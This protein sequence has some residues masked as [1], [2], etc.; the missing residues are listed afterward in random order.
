MNPKRIP[1]WTAVC[2]A[3]VLA[4][5][6][7][8]ALP[9]NVP[10]GRT[11]VVG[12]TNDSF[13]YT[14]IGPDGTLK[15]FNVD[16]LA[17]VMRSEHMNY[18]IIAA[19]AQ[20]ILTRFKAGEFDFM[21]E[22]VEQSDFNVFAEFSVPTI[23]T[24]MGI[25]V[26]T[27]SGISGPEDLAGRTVAFVNKGSLGVRYLTDHHIG[28]I[29]DFE[30]N[31]LT[32]LRAVADGRADATIIGRFTAQALM[33][34]NHVPGLRL[35]DISMSGYD[36]RRCLAVH[37]GDTALLAQLND[38]L[39]NIQ[40]NG[41]Y[42][43]IYSQ[44]KGKYDTKRFT[45][46]EVY[47]WGVAA[48]VTAFLAALW[49]LL[50]QRRLHRALSAQ[51]REISSQRALLQ[52][53]YD[54][55]PIG[56]TV[57][58]ATPSGPQVVLKNREA[59]AMTAEASRLLI[60]D[61]MR[62]WQAGRGEFQFDYDDRA[63]SRTYL[64]TV[65]PLT[66]SGGETGRLCVLFDDIT[67]RRRAEAEV[68]QSRKLRAVGELVGGIAHEFNN[69]LTPI[70]LKTGELQMTNPSAEEL[71]Q[72]LEV[73]AGAAMRG[74][75]LTRRLLT[76][77]RKTDSRPANIDVARIVE[78]CFKLLCNTVDRRIVWENAVP[79]GLAPL[80]FNET[81][82]N[83]IL[84][85]LLLNAR[86]T[87]LE[88]LELPH[89][90]DWQ[91]R[92][93]VGAGRLAPGDFDTGQV[94]PAGSSLEGWLRL[95]VSDNGMGIPGSVKERMFEP[96][97]TTKDVGKG[98]GLGLATIWHI[99]TAAG[100]S[101]RLMSTPEMGTTFDIYLPAWSMAQ[102]APP[103]RDE[104]SSSPA[105]GILRVLLVEDDALVADAITAVLERSAHRVRLIGD[106]REAAHVLATDPGSF[107]LLVLD[108]NL[109]GFSGVELVRLAREHR[110][111]AQILVMSG[112]VEESVR[113]TLESL[114]VHHFLKKPFALAEFEAA[115]RMCVAEGVG[116]PR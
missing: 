31:P 69:L 110:T 89:G 44:W 99:V 100:G 20:E 74:A 32:S 113:I 88:K 94:P 7:Q 106:G 38:G 97:F 51:T 52:A 108:V 29:L 50:R 55:I 18:R 77:A 80:W 98:T 36:L 71:D 40:R 2:F 92:V 112:R 79:A 12:I 27:G 101:V 34:Y 3:V 45:R 30:P 91:P 93:R 19:P 102:E 49:G 5:R 87:L 109:P 68:A 75:E 4:L 115:V 96:F 81:D 9:A 47:D 1:K 104:L 70:L 114:G 46:A 83:Q 64:V 15:G 72:E 33:D 116:S 103:E 22:L 17:A 26:R 78:G 62:R 105:T 10:A 111:T 63:T 84:M 95:S 43:R 57:V 42:Q 82:I 13:P 35:I 56:M 53:L 11:Y 73:I 86:D 21:A 76:F 58:A 23:T 59:D 6:G 37:R 8:T 48:L 90:A 67:E 66:D 16:V 61:A 107:D 28:A 25:V 14:Y 41:D 85:N 54:H 24:S 60:A 65:V 39:T